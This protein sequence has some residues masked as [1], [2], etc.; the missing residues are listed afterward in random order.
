MTNPI[1]A[2]NWI[3]IWAADYTP[4]SL[5]SCDLDFRKGISHIPSQ[6]FCMRSM[7]SSQHRVISHRRL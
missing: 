2:Y 3:E 5:M 4:E 6:V 7:F 1:Y